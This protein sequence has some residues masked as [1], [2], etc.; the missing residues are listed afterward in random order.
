MTDE[1][2]INAENQILGRL[3]SNTV[4]LLKEGKKVKIVNIEKAV[5]SGPKSRV[6]SGYKLL[7]TVRTMFN[8]E[9][10][11]I[12]RPKNPINIAKRT[13]RGMLPKTPKGKEMFKSLIIYV[14]VPA[15]LQGKE[16]ISFSNSSVSRLKGKY[17]TVGELASELGWNNG[18]K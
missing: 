5:I 17:I 18:R 16:T 15:E 13:I 12:R 14:G 11:G 1:V 8:P 3:C 7:F 10:Q 4:R 6:V 9:R 2:I